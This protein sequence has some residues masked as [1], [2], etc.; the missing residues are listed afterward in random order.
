MDDFVI[1]IDT[2]VEKTRRLQQTS[3]N[4]SAKESGV[5][6]AY[7]NHRVPNKMCKLT[8]SPRPLKTVKSVKY[9]VAR[10]SGPLV[11][12]VEVSQTPSNPLQFAYGTNKCE[13]LAKNGHMKTEDVPHVS[14][15]MKTRV[16]PRIEAVFSQTN[17]KEL[18]GKLGIHSHITSCVLDRFKLTRL[19][20]IQEAALPPLLKG[21]DC[22]IRAQTGSGKTLAYAVPLFHRLVTAQPP[23]CRKDG[24]LAL[25]IL[26]TRE[27]AT[28]TFEVFQTLTNSCVRIVSGCLIG[29]V[30]RKSQKVR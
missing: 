19:T 26:P 12:D 2:G 23:I 30:S 25:I 5:K 7:S 18:C 13:Q 6:D 14:S 11:N 1:N 20:A 29:G 9:A 27:L 16:E 17:W 4:V 10:K 28:Q 21:H 15:L 24:S 8:P 3:R 22:L